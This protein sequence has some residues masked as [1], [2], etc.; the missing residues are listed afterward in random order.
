VLCLG[1]EFPEL[2]LLE[3]DELGVQLL[4]RV[5]LQAGQRDVHAT[6]RHP[7]EAIR[8][9]VA[10]PDPDPDQSDPC[11][12]AYRIRIHK[13]EVRIRILIPSSKNRKK[14]LDSYC[15]VTSF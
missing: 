11:F 7:R 6:L 15:F 13:S 10:D 2:S 12:W 1:L 14:N 9:N 5:A 8:G 4:G 3:G